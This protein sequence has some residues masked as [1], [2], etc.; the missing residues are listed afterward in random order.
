M[1]SDYFDSAPLEVAVGTTARSAQVNAIA[2]AIDVGLAKL[3][4]EDEIKQGLIR[5]GVSGGIANVYTVAGTYTQTTLVDGLE[6]VF[7]VAVANTGPSTLNLDSLGA[8]SIVNS[9]GLALINGDLGAGTILT[10]RFDA[11]NDRWVTQSA[12]YGYTERSSQFASYSEEWAVKA[13]D[14]LISTDAGGDGSTDYSALHHAAKA[15][16]SESAAASSAAGAANSE[17]AAA[18]SETNAAASESAAA[19]SETNAAASELAAGTSETN[20][21]ASELA[22]GTS[23]TNAAASESAAAASE[24]AAATSETNAAASELA[25]GT[26]ETNAAASYDQ[27]DDRYLGAKASDPVLDNDGD[28]LITGALYWNT[29]SPS[30]RVYDGAAWQAFVYDPAAVGITGGTISGL[31]SLSVDGLYYQA[32]TI[33]GN[34]VIPDGVNAMVMSPINFTGTVEGVGSATLRGI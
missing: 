15:A 19:I 32:Q 16:A 7:K 9:A 33:A 17:S 31:T 3:P 6:V 11:T 21:A 14:S 26:S 2:Q 28:A 29:T 30:M 1:A 24:L 10:V 20:A 25:A 13:E 27:F 12:T 8:K 34:I 23:E 22:A 5:Y 18:I 4:T